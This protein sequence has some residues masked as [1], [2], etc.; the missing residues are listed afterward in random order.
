MSISGICVEVNSVGCMVLV[1]A[2]GFGNRFS[3]VTANVVL[4]FRVTDFPRPFGSGVLFHETFFW[5]H[6]DRNL[7]FPSLELWPH[8]LHSLKGQYFQKLI[9]Q[10]PLGVMCLS[11]FFHETFFWSHLD[12][13]LT[14]PSLEFWLHWLH[15]LKRQ[16]FQNF[17]CYLPLIQICTE[18]L[19]ELSSSSWSWDS[20][21]GS[22]FWLQNDQKQELMVWWRTSQPRKQNCT[23]TQACQG[24]FQWWENWSE[25]WL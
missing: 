19:E 11:A 20:F 5:S 21:A 3:S 1:V 17:D 16:Y 10:D 13:N 4:F 7:S 15:S 6:L 12:R 2:L 18:G 14:S 23:K 24:F 25:L 22:I 9:F 8:W